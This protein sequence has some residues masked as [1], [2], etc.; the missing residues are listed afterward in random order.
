[1]V[2]WL[3]YLQL[4]K[5]SGHIITNDVSSNSAHGEVYSIQHY[6][7]KKLDSDLLSVISFVYSSFLHQ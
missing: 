4:S 5:Q 6:L 3:L 1:M 2:V 7:K